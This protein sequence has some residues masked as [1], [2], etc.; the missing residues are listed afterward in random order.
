VSVPVS[1]VP[2]PAGVTPGLAGSV[3]AGEGRVLVRVSAR[4]GAVLA[5]VTLPSGLSLTSLA[6]GPGGTYLYAAAQRLRPLG[7]VVQEYSVSTGRLVAQSGMGPLTWAIS[8]AWL[9]AVPGG[10]WVWFRTGMLGQSVLLRAGSLVLRSR[11]SEVF[12]GAD[13]PVTGNGTVYY[14]AMGSAAVYGGGALWVTTDGGLVACVNPATGT[15]R[16]EETVTAQ[17]GQLAVML[18]ADQGADA[19]SVVVSVTG[20]AGLVTIRPPRTCWN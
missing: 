3:W 1:G 19:V 18:T 7:T 12:G 4:T 8:G 16:A 2:G 15:V 13:S 5:R 6:A 14:W 9:T 20:Y 11:P 10:I 17:E